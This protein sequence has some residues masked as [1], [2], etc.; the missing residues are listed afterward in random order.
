MAKRAELSGLHR[1]PLRFASYAQVSVDERAPDPSEGCQ[2]RGIGRV[3]V[4]SNAPERSIE[5]PVTVRGARH[6]RY[7]L[8]LALVGSGGR[9]VPQTRRLYPPTP[10]GGVC[11]FWGYL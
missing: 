1:L 3:G 10:D 6:L 9:A 11:P 2:A 8:A 4:R 7:G 5:T